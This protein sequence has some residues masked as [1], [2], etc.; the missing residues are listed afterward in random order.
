MI[1]PRGECLWQSSQAPELQ[2]LFLGVSEWCR[3]FLCEPVHSVQ[4]MFGR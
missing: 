4:K 3:C 2:P 1:E